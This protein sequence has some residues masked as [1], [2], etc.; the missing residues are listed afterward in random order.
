MR[1]G[2]RDRDED[3]C[4]QK[5]IGAVVHPLFQAWQTPRQKQRAQLPEEVAEAQKSEETSQGSSSRAGS[6]IPAPVCRV[7][8]RRSPALACLCGV[9]ARL[10]RGDSD[11]LSSCA[12]PCLVEWVQVP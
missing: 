12:D 1:E 2:G 11:A 3:S 10:C 9:L 5:N 8:A 6:K 7:E 4:L